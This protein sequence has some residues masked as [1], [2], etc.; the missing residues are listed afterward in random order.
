[1]QG[2]NLPHSSNYFFLPREVGGGGGGVGG[3][4]CYL[5]PSNGCCPWTSQGPVAPCT[6]AFQFLTAELLA[7]LM[8]RLHK[9]Y[10]LF[11]W[12]Q[13]NE[14]PGEGHVNR[15][16]PEKGTLAILIPSLSNHQFTKT[17]ISEG[18]TISFSQQSHLPMFTEQLY[19]CCCCC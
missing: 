16:A 13:S 6:P 14:R 4:H 7:M 10:Y 12:I 11:F 8:G 2:S 17:N 1:M 15:H 5:N 9:Q 19:C 18:E 3:G